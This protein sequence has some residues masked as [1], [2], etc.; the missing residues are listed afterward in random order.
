MQDATRSTKELQL[1]YVDWFT[2][3]PVSESESV[4]DYGFD[5]AQ[6]LLNPGLS[7]AGTDNTRLK[8][9]KVELFCLAPVPVIPIAAALPQ[10]QALTTP[11][12]ILA[13]VPA[14]AG[15]QGT[16]GNALL[17]QSTTTVHP[18]TRQ[19]W[20]HVGTWNWD[21]IFD[22]AQMQPVIIQE[23]TAAVQHLLRLSAIDAGTGNLFT[24]PFNNRLTFEIRI[25]LSCPLPLLSNPVRWVGANNNWE[26][27]MIQSDMTL[28]DT[29]CQVV[30]KKLQNIM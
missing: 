24:G 6:N 4:Y 7:D 10:P 17:G 18:D 28:D 15:G 3:T 5:I 9:Q 27:S 26:S 2:W 12:S 16:I 11:I 13:A 14:E 20:V 8:V 21:K 22:N 30:L 25:T 23:S 29:P 1:E 19:P